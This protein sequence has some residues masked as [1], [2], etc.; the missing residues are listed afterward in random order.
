MEA[1]TLQELTEYGKHLGLKEII[2]ERL[3]R[4]ASNQGELRAAERTQ[5]TEAREY[6]LQRETQ[7]IEKRKLEEKKY[8][9]DVKSKYHANVQLLEQKLVF[10]KTDVKTGK[11]NG[12]EGSSSKIPKMPYFNENK[13]DIDSSQTF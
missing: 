5:S 9:E 10:Q 8:L 11:S 7:E 12:S 1:S 2:L 3:L 4:T 13:A 6:E